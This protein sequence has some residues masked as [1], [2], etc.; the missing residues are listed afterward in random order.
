[1]KLK[2][3]EVLL[4]EQ[5]P[6]LAKRI[7]TL[8][9]TKQTLVFHVAWVRDLV[10][11]TE[12][13]NNNPIDIVLLD[14]SVSNVKSADF[15]EQILLQTPRA[16]IILLCSSLDKIF[17]L[18]AMTKGACDCLD[19]KRLGQNWLKRVLGYN[20]M[21]ANADK[22]G[23]ISDA[24][25]QAIGNTSSLGI[26]VSDMA[27]FIIYTNPAFHSITGFSAKQSFGQHWAMVIHADD[28]TRLEH[29]WREE[30]LFQQTF[31][32]DVLLVR[33]NNGA[34]RAR[35]T[36]NFIKDDKE[37]FGYVRT[38]E[39]LTESCKTFSSQKPL[40]DNDSRWLPEVT[41]HMTLDALGNAVLST[42]ISGR[43]VY[44]NQA[45]ERLTGW[46]SES[47]VGC[48]LAEV[49]NLKDPSASDTLV[50]H[51]ELTLTEN[52]RFPLPQDSILIRKD[53]VEVMVDETLAPI[54]DK[55]GQIVGAVLIFRDVTETRETAIKMTHLAKHDS[56]T[57][58]PN[59]LLLKERLNQAISLAN[60]HN[61]K[62]ALLYM[63]ID[64]FKK[65]NDSHGHELGDK[66]LCSVAERM[67]ASVRET[68]TVCR[69]GGDEFVLLLSEIEHPNDAAK[70]ANKLLNR[71]AN[72]HVIDDKELIVSMSIGIAIFPNDGELSS[73]LMDSADSAMFQAKTSG[74]NCYRFFKESM[75]AIAKQQTQ[76]EIRIKRALL[77]NEFI[78]HYQPLFNLET[79]EICGAE[80][81]IRW[82]DPEF[83][84]LYPAEFIPI[85]EQSTLIYLIGDLLRRKVCL[86]Q[87][88][89]SSQG[90]TIVPIMINT[91]AIELTQ[92]PFFHEVE[93]ALT[94]C[95]LAPEF[96]GLEVTESTI[97]LSVFPVIQQLKGLGVKLVLDNFGS[98]AG[99]LSFLHYL[100]FSAVKI[101]PDIIQAAMNE[102][103]KA[104]IVHALI[105]LA[106]NL[107][108]EIIAKGIES[109]QQLSFV[110]RC[111]CNSAQGNFFNQ[112]LSAIAF[113]H[114]LI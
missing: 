3:V 101:A 70:L 66:L 18:Q 83:G 31:H 109:Q 8:L 58:L 38:F 108:Q 10:Q 47:A 107:D 26:M 81:L 94:D 33:Q 104:T 102:S 96:L 48:F 105:G 64:L 56:L 74:R 76:I 25:L 20:L 34:C 27:G 112:P 77:Q 79:G 19:K 14:L 23:A 52:Q 17:A 57:G 75:R 95:G 80:A 110:E 84:L 87:K 82:Q 65:I 22:M 69:Q 16:I 7:R 30:L 106:K 6:S 21:L 5:C 41:A 89:W 114:L 92:K 91:S 39:L 53:G 28:R 1:M 60:R 93:L 88:D 13:M 99:H 50:E 59:R 55:Q 36:G 37:L 29:E 12:L 46:K 71:M 72:P 42:D 45:A 68:D 61:K 86:Q 9:S 67:K 35:M 98:D 32:S 40:L 2:P 100:A 73:V 85:A 111:Q 49:F 97:T 54:N 62:L 43:V 78:L 15:V 63:D 44:L 4:V 51:V 103:D 113:A 24:R 11:A 90:L